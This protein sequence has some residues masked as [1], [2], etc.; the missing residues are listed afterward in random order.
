MTE[1]NLEEVLEEYAAATPNGNDLKILRTLSE[2]HLE[3]ADDLADF[4]AA[5]A[6]VKHAPDEE[7]S[8]EEEQRFQESGMK[9]LR[10]VLSL[11]NAA[12]AAENAL[13]SLV[14]TAKAK[15]FNRSRFAAAVGLST[16]L[17]MYLEK[18]RLDFSSIPQ[19]IVVNVARILETG[20][21]LVSNYLNQPPDLA[22]GASFKTNAR[23][24]DL[25]PKS[26]AEA[27]REDQ[28]LSAEEKRKL[29]DLTGR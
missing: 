14:E 28:Q 4:A 1:S 17:V 9:S 11:L 18:R 22:T 6:V 3:R 16:S 19:A 15:G 23:A 13:Q 27:V 20:E 2:A 21:D 29:L 10:A 25:P 8:A 5:R 12:G 24:E 26:F 7:L